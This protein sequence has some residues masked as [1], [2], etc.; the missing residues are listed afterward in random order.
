MELVR[1]T[2]QNDNFK[3]LLSL[4]FGSALAIALDRSG[5]MDEERAAVEAQITEII[6]LVSTGKT[7]WKKLLD[8]NTPKINK[9]LDSKCQRIVHH[10]L[11]FILS[12]KFVNRN[13]TKQWTSFVLKGQL[14]LKENC[15][16]M[17]S[18]KKRTNEFIF[19]Y[20]ATCVCSFFGRNWRLQKGISK[21][22]DI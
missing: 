1:K 19:Y 14:I 8:L 5:S 13:W 12:E 15:Q 16:A 6:K 7:P 18:S 17:N 10:L 2:I 11:F 3:S 20:Y 21:L 22:S 4:S 9:L